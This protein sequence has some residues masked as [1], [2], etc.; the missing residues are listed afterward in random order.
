MQELADRPSYLY[1]YTN[2]DGYQGILA[3]GIIMPSFRESRWV[4]HMVGQYLTDISPKKVL[5]NSEWEFIPTGF[6]TVEQLSLEIFGNIRLQSKLD[7]FI[8]IDVTG[9]DI[10]W[11]GADCSNDKHIYVHRSD[12]D[13]NIST[14]IISHG[15]R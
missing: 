9:L 8:E 12:T 11:C 2:R 14:R 1:H 5:P 10:Y 3:T 13:L 6:F 4:N 15:V 7:C